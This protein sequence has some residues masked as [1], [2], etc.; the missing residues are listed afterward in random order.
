M[1]QVPTARAGDF[2]NMS[3]WI[4]ALFVAGGHTR[5]LIMADFANVGHVNLAWKGYYFLTQLGHEAVML[6]F[7]ISGFLVGG[8]SLTRF[9]S[10][11]FDLRH[12]AVHRFARIYTVFV[13]TLIL[14][15]LLDLAGTH[16]FAGTGL[17]TEQL[18]ISSIGH[19]AIDA[20]GPNDFLGNAA[21]LQTVVVP[22]LGTNG[23]LWSLANEW[24]YY[25]IFAAAMTMAAAA[26]WAGKAAAAAILTGLLLFL[27]HKM[28]LWGAIWLLGAGVALYA[29]AGFWRPPA[30]VSIMV[31]L[32]LLILSRF[33]HAIGAGR[34]LGGSFLIDLGVAFGYSLVL[35]SMHR[36]GRRNR[37][38]KL[39]ARLASFSYTLYLIHFPL[40]VF[41]VA[42]LATAFGITPLAQPSVKGLALW[43]A[44]VAFLLISAWGFARLFEARTDAVRLGLTRMLGTG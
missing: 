12:Y 39:H 42:F 6:F 43:C 15:G 33:C 30:M 17:Y 5:Q 34:S 19:P 40:M 20:L 13:P 22:A 21:M 41:S 4:A 29:A 1:Q 8:R 37:L 28:I 9:R 16:I 25:C 18:H 36:D 2:L 24:W 7:V 35:L 31:A 11:G 14:L 38:A 3:R 26:S 32:P 10:K 23:P 44:V 27:P